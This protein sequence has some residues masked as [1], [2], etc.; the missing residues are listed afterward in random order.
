MNITEAPLKGLLIIQPRI[1][2]DERGFFFESFQAEKYQALGIPNFVQDNVSCSKLHVLRGLHYQQPHPQGKL[3]WVSK[4]AVWDVV[5]DIRRASPTFGRWFN[6]TL[7]A[8]THTQFY[9]PPGFAHGFCTL[10]DDTVFHY[11]CTD[12]YSPQTERGI[13]WDDPALNIPWPVKQ[14]VLSPKDQ[15]YPSLTEIAHEHLF[16]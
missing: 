11:K 6:I 10:E 16:A 7:N 13:A 14:P 15:H 4:G 1:F 9:V 5:V 2:K 3:V 8:E 12:Y